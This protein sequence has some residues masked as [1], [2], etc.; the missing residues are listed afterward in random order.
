M[1]E[2]SEDVVVLPSGEKVTRWEKR[3][4]GIELQIAKANIKRQM[5][6]YEEIVPK[7]RG[8]YKGTN[9]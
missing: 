6:Q 3:E 8:I 4:I 2:G 5:K 7:S 1:R 9:G